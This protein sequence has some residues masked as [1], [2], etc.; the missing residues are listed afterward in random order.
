MTH[1][2]LMRGGELKF[3]FSDEKNAAWSHRALKMPYSETSRR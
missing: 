3:V 1:E 2:E